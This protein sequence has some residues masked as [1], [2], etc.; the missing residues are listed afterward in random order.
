MPYN[1]KIV[2]AGGLSP[3]PQTAMAQLMKAE[4]EDLSKKQ[5]A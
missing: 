2:L 3:H 4:T 5:P 1:Q